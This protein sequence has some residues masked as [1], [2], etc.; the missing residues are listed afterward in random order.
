VLSFLAGQL[1]MS[2]P[3]DLKPYVKREMTVNKHQHLI[4]EALGYTLFDDF[5]AFSLTRWMYRTLL[6]GDERPLALFEQAQLRLSSRKVML[7]GP[8]TLGRIIVQVRQRVSRLSYQV[9]SGRL[10]ASHRETLETLLLVPEGE[11]LSHLDTLR[12][13]PVRASTPSLLSALERLG[14]LRKLGLQ[15]VKTTDQ[16]PGRIKA[17]Q[18]L[19]MTAW[20]QTLTRWGET[21]RHATLLVAVQH[22]ERR[23]LS[24][25]LDVF[26]RLMTQLS[27]TGGQRCLGQSGTYRACPHRTERL[28]SLKDL[29]DAARVL[30]QAVKMLLEW[31]KK[32]PL[33][34]DKI[35]SHFGEDTLK[36]AAQQVQDLTSSEVSR[37]TQAWL[38]AQNTVWAFFARFLEG[39]EFEGTSSAKALLEAITFLKSDS[40]K[41]LDWDKAPR[42][43]VPK[44]WKAAVYSKSTGLNTKVYVLC[45]AQQLYLQLKGRQIYVPSSLRHMDPRAGLLSAEVWDKQRLDIARSLDRSLDPKI[46]LGQLE[47]DLDTAYKNTLETLP[48]NAALSFETLTHKERQEEVTKV[49][50][51]LT[52]LDAIPG[53]PTLKPLLLEVSRRMPAIDLSELVL[54]VN[55]YTRFAREFIVLKEGKD[56]VTEDPDLE[57]SICAVLVSQACNIPLR[58]VMRP[59]IPALT[60]TRLSYV[61]Q[62]Y[63]RNDTLIRANAKL[64]EAHSSLPLVQH[65]GSGEV[66]SADGLRFVVPMKSLYSAPNSKY[67]GRERGVTY[68]S[69]TS[70]QYTGFGGQ[71]IPGT[72][73]D[74]LYILAG[75]LEQDTSLMPKEIMTDTA[76]YTDI[77]F[78]LFH[79]LGYRFAPR[80]ADLKNTRFWRAGPTGCR[81]AQD[82]AWT[83]APIMETSISWPATRST[84]H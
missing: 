28:R 53:S 65:W 7:P 11:R 57:L 19:G 29:D 9:L 1:G 43:F 50:P 35:L 14:T 30:S 18:R 52:P 10:S 54:E 27:L 59:D 71:V 8:S 24:D 56:S 13:A 17:M 39:V 62:T 63:L 22:L 34:R 83:R 48:A 3:R 46:A 70:D 32:R 4:R 84:P 66:A 76:S 6:M 74:S 42:T 41:R 80:I 61:Q 49:L 64:V 21:R 33:A 75:L 38:G 31:K 5:Q 82:S 25:V 81:S 15:E 77:I 58:S 72:M 78:G 20:I 67:F 68:F 47:R 55:A 2:T 44:S 36:A 69:F 79:L 23:A 45:V 37:E 12:K 51:H 16:P 60:L 26:E 40:W 73:R